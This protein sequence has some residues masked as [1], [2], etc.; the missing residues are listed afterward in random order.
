MKA[1]LARSDFV[2]DSSDLEMDCEIKCRPPDRQTSCINKTSDS[3]DDV[4]EL[5]LMERIMKNSAPNTFVTDKTN[6]NLYREILSEINEGIAFT[7][8]DAILSSQLADAFS[9]LDSDDDLPDIEAATQ[10]REVNER[11]EAAV[12]CA[13]K[14]KQTAKEDREKKRAEKQR[15]KEFESNEK[16]RAQLERNILRQM[17]PGECLKVNE[18]ECIIDQ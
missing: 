8:R 5:G 10:A 18:S 9:H 13:S 4:I 12:N 6:N 7:K 14:R 16:Y 2:S 3:D 1:S 15:K 11:R 17:K